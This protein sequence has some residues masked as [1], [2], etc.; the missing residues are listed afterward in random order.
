MPQ[1]ALQYDCFDDQVKIDRDAPVNV[2]DLTEQL[3]ELARTL[4]REVAKAKLGD[5]LHQEL[6]PLGSVG[7]RF[8]ED[9]EAECPRCGSGVAYRKGG[10]PRAVEVPRLATVEVERPYLECRQCGRF[11]V[12][13]AAGI[14]K[15]RR[16]GPEAMRRPIEATME[17]S[18]QRGAEA[19]SESPSEHTLWR[20]VNEG[21]PEATDEQVPLEAHAKAVRTPKKACVAALPR[22]RK[23][24]SIASDRSRGRA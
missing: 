15:R 3:V 20:L 4:V 7:N 2:Y 1:I 14:P 24:L 13:Y 11:Y 23:G 10:R 6:G 5:R 17:T 22:A 16:Y 19:Y 21:S 8:R 9:F 18:Y 12:P